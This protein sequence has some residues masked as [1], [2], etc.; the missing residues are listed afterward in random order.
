MEL[1]PAK[2]NKL[3]RQ[4]STKNTKKINN[5]IIYLEK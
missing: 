4:N 1:K 3:I 2:I 5:L